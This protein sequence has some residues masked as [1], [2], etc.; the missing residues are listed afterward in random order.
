MCGVAG[1]ISSNKEVLPYIH[2]MIHSLYHRGPD[3]QNSFIDDSNGVA[4]GHTRLSILDLSAAANQPMHSMDNRFV[5]CFNGEIYNFKNLRSQ[6][7]HKYT[8]ITHSD[9]EVLLN[10][11]SEW[12]SGMLVHL[13]GMF[14][15]AI[16]DRVDKSLFLARD[17]MGKKP[18]Y[19]LATKESFLFASEIKALVQYPHADLSI[20]N[21]AAFNFLHV[22]YIG[23]NQSIYNH[24]KKIP[25]GHFAYVT[26]DKPITT[27][28]FWNV[29][30]FFENGDDTTGNV[31][32]IL[33]NK[34]FDAVE[35]RL[36]S[37]VPVG[38]FLSGGTDSSM[39]AAIASKITSNKIKSFSIGFKHA[40][41]NEL[42]Y[43]SRVAKA[44]HLDHHA[45]ELDS[46]EGLDVMETY[47][48]HFDEPFADTSAIATM[49]V[50]KY[51]KEHVSV[52][53][54][55][56]GGDELFLGYGAYTWAKRL[57][58]PWISPIRGKLLPHILRTSG[59]NR[60]AGKARMFENVQKEL[61][62]SHVFSQEQCFFSVHEINSLLINP[63][64]FQPNIYHDPSDVVQ[65]EEE[66]QALYDL[67]HYLQ[68]DLLVK[69]DR[70]SMHN[71]LEC[72]S[73]LLDYDVIAYALQLPIH[74][75]RKGDIHKK[76]L[77]EIL[78]D[79]LPEELI[80]RP[81]LGFSVPLVSWL[82]NEL[83]D[84]IDMYLSKA[85]VE[86]VGLVKF[87]AIQPTIKSFINGQDYLYH[88]IWVLIV[89]HK[90][91]LT[92]GR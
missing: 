25:A 9:T 81:K 64:V 4:L 37:D 21:N 50:S 76:V 40:K 63:N 80:H 33:K 17:R 69:I 20:D 45:Y 44:L 75:K 92:H 15:L 52:A 86:Q 78:M 72:R 88:R 55:G 1:I 13:E 58:Q 59:Y 90:W 71:A 29:H 74:Y 68:D 3:A 79:Y 51:A 22:G 77:K 70:A 87:E 28:P 54:T 46:K 66:Y 47:L 49:L 8:F 16:Y 89:L 32:D 56:D 11:Y 23:T 60:F 19:Y 65:Q 84:W 6:L 36:I 83:R 43:A 35:K 12:G 91:M 62:R 7:H 67:Q 26:L 27:I 39:V 38:C 31:K 85:S 30:N 48:N 73:P 2:T 42:I 41:S 14:A 82:R 34:L 24:I 61:F 53:L 57:R 10:A 5:I 18:L